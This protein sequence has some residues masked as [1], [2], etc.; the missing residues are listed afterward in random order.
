MRMSRAHNGGTIREVLRVL[1]ACTAPAA[2]GLACLA[3]NATAA[4]VTID[5]EEF[6]G[7]ANMPTPPLIS[8]GFVLDP[9]PSDSR[10]G[11]GGWIGNHYH[12][13]EP[14]NPLWANNGTKFMVVD[15][16]PTDVTKLTV[17]SASGGLFGVQRIDLAEAASGAFGSNGCLGAAMPNPYVIAF[18]G[19]LANGGTIATQKTLDMICDDSGP[20]VDFETFSFDGQWNLLTAFSVQQLTLGG[21]YSWLGIDNIDLRTVAA[22]G[23][24]AVTGLGLLGLA[25]VQRR[26]LSRTGRRKCIAV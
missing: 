23:T 24:L 8:K 9:G 2:L 4:I 22:P 1:R 12:V 25:L 10:N 6:V 18:T 17:S 5:F 26:T 16:H 7:D 13:A 20:L 3:G 21:P 11:P 19:Q 14:T 15:Y